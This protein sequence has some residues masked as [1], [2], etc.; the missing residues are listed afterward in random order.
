MDTSEIYS[1]GILT[2]RE[3]ILHANFCSM[4]TKGGGVFVITDKKNPFF[5]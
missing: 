4:Q 5:K 1:S 3:D 2:K